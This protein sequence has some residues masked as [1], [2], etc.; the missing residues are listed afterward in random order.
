LNSD[1]WYAPTVSSEPATSG[2]MHGYLQ[3]NQ[4]RWLQQIIAKLEADKNIDHIFLT[5]HTPVFS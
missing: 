5:Q 1:Y 2:G 4:L 3:D